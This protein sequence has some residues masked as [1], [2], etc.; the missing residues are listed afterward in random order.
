MKRLLAALA[1]PLLFAPGMAGA[2]DT[3]ILIAYH[4][5]KGHT[6]TM[7]E[8]VADGAREVDGVTVTVR[9]VGEVT[10]AEVLA[11][12]AIIVGSPVYN[13]NMAPEVQRF[14]NG[15]PFRGAPMRD[16]IGAAFAT[17]GA[18]SAGE[19]TVQ[20]SI[21]RSMLVFGMVIAGGPSWRSAFGASAITEE[22][23]FE[24]DS[25][26]GR[27]AEPFAERGRAL[28]RRVAEL[29]KRFA[30]E[31]DR[32]NPTASDAVEPANASAISSGGP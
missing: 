11:A 18:F 22:Q 29:A 24:Q 15:W 9:G 32:E 16:K 23:P 7:A 19:E 28:G 10:E 6:R 26:D 21:L 27:V 3:T 20:L 13:A 25:P 8:A 31:P 14:I 5:V 4:S 12:D 17:G 1:L 30:A 2:E